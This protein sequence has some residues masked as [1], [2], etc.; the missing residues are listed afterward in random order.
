MAV[1]DDDYENKTKY[2]IEND[3][4]RYTWAGYYLFLIL[5]SLIGDT[6]I[7]V[8]SIKY[9]AFKLH[10]VVVV[11]IQHIAVSDLTLTFVT[12]IVTLVSILAEKWV[13]GFRLC[14]LITYAD[15]YSNLV[16]ILLISVMTTSKM[17]LL[18]YP[19][20]FGNTSSK[21]AHIICGS[22]WA[23]ALFLPAVFL[24]VDWDDVY[25]SY[26]SY[27]CALGF[28]A[29]IWRYLRPIL[30][31]ICILAPTCLV[32]ANSVQLLVMARKIARNAR[33]SMKWQGIITTI[34]IAAVFCLS[35]VPY[36]LIRIFNVSS[37]VY[38]RVATS[39]LSLN[40]VSNFYIYSLGGGPRPQK[41]PKSPFF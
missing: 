33:Q 19:I 24:L 2:R 31:V 25:F 29:G 15:Y 20:R 7:L 27:Q 1:M 16:N 18:K 17:L 40:V 41:A 13:F 35:L 36:I 23:V 14:L 5:S 12:L 37:G 26:R 6:T 22:C 38:I 28:T 21:T 4:L 30:S 32:V 11:N 9:K 34:L 8:A 39:F 10:E 3:A